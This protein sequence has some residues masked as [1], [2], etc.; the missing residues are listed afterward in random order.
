M[1]TRHYLNTEPEMLKAGET[2]SIMIELLTKSESS[3][4]PIVLKK[5]IYFNSKIGTQRRE[6]AKT[7]QTEQARSEIQL[8]TVIK[9]NQPVQPSLNGKYL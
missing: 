1:L 2:G 8:S 5:A 3:M 4:N 7:R 6:D 9:S